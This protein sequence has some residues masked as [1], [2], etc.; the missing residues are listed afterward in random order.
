[1]TSHC[2]GNPASDIRG[3]GK[4]RN[5][6]PP[7]LVLRQP[8]KQSPIE[9]QEACLHLQTLESAMASL[10][11]STQV[12][13]KFWERRPAR[14]WRSMSCSS[15]NGCEPEKVESKTC[16]H[17]PKYR[18]EEANDRKLIAQVSVASLQEPFTSGLQPG[19][20]PHHVVDIRGLN[21]LKASVDA[22]DEIS[23]IDPIVIIL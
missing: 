8:I 11:P 7:F 3:E 20:H 9:S 23:Q 12:F 13:Q 17:T 10:R 4:N 6:L 18:P 14:G 5:H 21:R 16:T 19:S 2:T 22:K 15:R 1:M